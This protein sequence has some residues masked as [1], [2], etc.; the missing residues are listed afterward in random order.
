MLTEDNAAA[1]LSRHLAAKGLVDARAREALEAAEAVGRRE[2]LGEE[3]LAAA[4]LWRREAKQRGHLADWARHMAELA[5]AKAAADIDAE[6]AATREAMEADWARAIEDVGLSRSRHLASIEQ[7]FARRRALD[8][9]AGTA[10]L[11]LLSDEADA[12]GDLLTFHCREESREALRIADRAAEARR[13]AME[14]AAKRHEE[15]RA[16]VEALAERPLSHLLGMVDVEGLREAVEAACRRV[17]ANRRRQGGIAVSGRVG[18]PPP[19]RAASRGASASFAGPSPAGDD[20]VVLTADTFRELLEPSF[21]L[22]RQEEQQQQQQ[23][24]QSRGTSQQRYP[25]RLSAVAAFRTVSLALE[26]IKAIDHNSLAQLSVGSMNGGSNTQSDAGASALSAEDRRPSSSAVALRLRGLVAGAHAHGGGGVSRQQHVCPLVRHLDLSNNSLQSLD[27]EGLLGAAFGSL[28]RIVLAGNALTVLD[29]DYAESDTPPN[30]AGGAEDSS[31]APLSASASLTSRGA[32]SDF[33]RLVQLDASANKLSSLSGVQR[34]SFLTQL[35]AYGNRLTSLPSDL[36]A[37]CPLLSVVEISRNELTD[38]SPLSGLKFLQSLDCGRNRIASLDPIARSAPLLQRLYA[39]HN[40]LTAL[41]RDACWV[42]LQHLFVS[43][44]AIEHLNGLSGCPLLAVLSAES[45]KLVDVEGLRCCP[46]LASATLSFN[47]LEGLEALLPLGYCPL[48]ERLSISD[49]PVMMTGS[50]SGAGGGGVDQRLALAAAHVLC[51]QLRELNN[52]AV[53]PEGRSKALGGSETAAPSRGEGPYPVEAELEAAVLPWRTVREKQKRRQ[54]EVSGSKP[55]T[56]ASP[57]ATA[58]MAPLV[59][60][61]R[62]EYSAVTLHYSR[63]VSRAAASE[64]RLLS[65]LRGDGAAG[66]ERGGSTFDAKKGQKEAS[67]GVRVWGTFRDSSEAFVDQCLGTALLLSRHYQML[68]LAAARS[69]EEGATNA[70]ADTL[71]A[72]PVRAAL[73]AALP[74]L[75]LGFE[76]GAREIVGRFLVSRIRIGQA[77]RQL[78]ALRATTTLYSDR[79]TKI[80]SVFR[81]H[82][83]RRALRGVGTD[84]DDDMAMYTKVDA[85]LLGPSGAASHGG[86]GAVMRSALQTHG[87]APVFEVRKAPP[88]SDALAPAS[89]AAGGAPTRLGSAPQPSNGGLAVRGPATAGGTLAGALRPSSQPLMSPSGVLHPSPPRAAPGTADPSPP[90]TDEW[91]AAIRQHL[92][93]KTAKVAK[94]QA[95]VMRREFVNDPLRARQMKK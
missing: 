18:T 95:E 35:S 20:G 41:P 22:L 63:Q 39:S 88:P 43:D 78:A 47:A 1:R 55:A 12:W 48:L 15:R 36:A 68:L 28:R 90:P 21:A 33:P 45:N 87:A 42:F 74:S 75:S 71:I 6:E 34:F 60:F 83:V 5:K 53:T 19:P 67:A 73:D 81:G 27:C 72:D 40:S 85:G 24:Q 76:R 9:A 77:K 58:A 31:A 57:T 79:A 70:L 14:E 49:N 62:R 50:G 65:A 2:A 44:N 3:G 84:D 52:D 80:Q 16:A 7:N 66:G 51:P 69:A 17:L 92:H 61:V 54:A 29:G 4:D 94:Q 89:M 59:A 56:S 13:K 93:K 23:Q 32:P 26:H 64:G 37:R 10:H 38:L 30:T 46:F 8:G 82:R 91:S 11:S 86:V 25:S